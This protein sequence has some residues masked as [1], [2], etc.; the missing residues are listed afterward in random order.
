MENIGIVINST[1]DKDGSVEKFIMDFLHEIKK[2][3]KILMLKSFIDLCEK[4][5]SEV[6]NLDM[7]ISFG[8]DGTI[9]STARIV[10]KYGIPILGVNMGNLGFLSSAEYF[11]VKKCVK[12]VL[13]GDYEIEER[14][15][16]KCTANINS[17]CKDYYTLNDVV[18]SKGALARILE[19]KIKIDGKFYANFMADGIIISTPTG[20][21]AYSL[22][23][24]G[25][26]MYPTLDMISI[27]PI[28]PL[29]LGIR[30]LVIHSDSEIHIDINKKC[31]SVYLS[32]DGQEA[33]ELKNE[34]NFTV[35][36]ANW[37]CKLIRIN[38]Y[39]YFKVLRKKII[40]R[41]KECEGDRL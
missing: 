34:D 29:P 22:S 38:G 5:E 23:A 20:S 26:I 4:E 10:S 9:L 16:L 27:T 17:E 1:K 19:Y 2:D 14:T 12:K 7:I 30:T 35:T 3:L 40:L 31:Q 18:I 21:T 36:K 11:D 25:P 41:T 8:G 37:K 28:C 39:D 13:T 33:L 6:K 24:G 15:M 32:L